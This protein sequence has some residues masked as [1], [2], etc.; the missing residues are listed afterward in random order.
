[1]IELGTKKIRNMIKRFFAFVLAATMAISASAQP[2][3]GSLTWQP[4]VGITYTTATLDDYKG[5]ADGAVGL[6]AGVEAMYMLNE[7]LGITLGLNYTGYNINDDVFLG[8]YHSLFYGYYGYADSEFYERALDPSPEKASNYYFNIPV[9]GNYYVIPGLAVKAGV[10][11]NVLSTAKVRGKTEIDD[12]KIRDV[13]K[14]TFISLPFGA[15]YEIKNF[16]FD[17]RYNLSVTDICEYDDGTFHSFALTV[18]Y[19]F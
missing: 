18:G 10:T 8:R 5:T 19:R 4:N 17:A 11:F 6:T 1:M 2:E 12:F 15:S 14:S 7:K 9:I 16:V 13:Y 3:A